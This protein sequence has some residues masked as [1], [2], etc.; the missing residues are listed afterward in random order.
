VLSEQAIGQTSA[1]V[2]VAGAADAW[3]DF[4]Q[5][6]GA[7]ESYNS[8]EKEHLPDFAEV[9]PSVYSLSVDP[10]SIIYNT[11]LLDEKD[12][13]TGIADLAKKVRADPDQF[14]GANTVRNPKGAFGF[15]ITYAF[16][17]N[18]PAAWDSLA[19]ILPYS[20]NETSTGSQIEKVTAG[21]YTVGFFMGSP[22]LTDERRTGGL[23]EAV[24]PD[25]GTPLLRRGMAVLQGAPHPATAKLF[26]DF[27]L[28]AEGQAAAT[29]G[30]LTAYRDGVTSPEGGVA[31]Y[32]DVVTEVGE[33]NTI[34]IPCAS[35]RWRRRSPTGCTGGRAAPSRTRS[36]PCP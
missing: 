11:A 18:N 8:P 22:A 20:R 30:G 35:T 17:D 12:R 2:I 27:A 13:P 6:P 26:L 10:I 19:A 7:V 36:P 4:V 24:F 25:D 29:E 16:V 34:L 1:D 15:T 31:T 14:D 33:E 21:E 23:I 32:D 28:S 5:R 3:A 9:L